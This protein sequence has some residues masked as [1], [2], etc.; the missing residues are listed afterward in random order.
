MTLLLVFSGL[1][2]LLIAI[3]WA[4]FEWSEDRATL[5]IET[6]AIR[7]GTRKAMERAKQFVAWVG[8]RPGANRDAEHAQSHAD[9]E[10]SSATAKQSG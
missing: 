10:Q 3:D 1:L 7:D 8:R 2:L 9:D 6:R 4:R 5:T